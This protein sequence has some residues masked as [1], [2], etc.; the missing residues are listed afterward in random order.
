MPYLRVYRQQRRAAAGRAFAPLVSR[1]LLVAAAHGAGPSLI[2]ST[3][4][5]ARIDINL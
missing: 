2:D 5:V 3:M 1:L 4:I